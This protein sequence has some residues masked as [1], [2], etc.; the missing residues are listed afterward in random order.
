MDSASSVT[1]RAETQSHE[2][3][4]AEMEWGSFGIIDIKLKSLQEEVSK[5]DAEEQMQMPREPDIFR[6]KALQ[7]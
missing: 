6:K 2:K 4:T 3:T 7:S 1:F 5:L